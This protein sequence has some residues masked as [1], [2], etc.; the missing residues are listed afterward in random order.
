[1]R[2]KRGRFYINS[3][4][5]CYWITEEFTPSGKK[6]K[7]DTSER[8]VTGYFGKLEDC[9]KD[10]V[11]KEISSSEAHTMTKLMEDIEKAKADLLELI[12]DE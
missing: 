8:R 10:F 12:N 7:K 9:Y 1:M 6:A 2:I 5:R 11:N 3:D 4:S